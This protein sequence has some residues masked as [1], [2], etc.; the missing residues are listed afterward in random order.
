[1]IGVYSRLAL[2]VLSAV[3]L[4]D[5]YCPPDRIHG[6][7]LCAFRIHCTGTIRGVSLP[8]ECRGSI[9]HPVTVDLTLTEGIERFDNHISDTEFLNVVTTFRASAVWQR[10][11]LSFLTYMTRLKTLVLTENQIQRIEGTPFFNL[12]YLQYLDLSRNSLTDIEDLFQFETQP[13]RLEKLFLSNNS[14]EEIPGDAFSELTSLKE[15]DLSHNLISNFDEEPFFNLTSLE[16]LRLNNNRI[17]DLN[18]AVNK[19]VNL[20]H[21]Y[22]KG[23]QIQNI[24]DPSLKIIYHL[25]TFD[26]SGNQLEKLRPIMFSRHWQHFGGVVRIIL[27]ENHITSV[28]NG[29]SSEVSARFTRELSKHT[30]ETEVS[31]ELDLSKNLISNIE[32]HA[33]QS[34]VRLINLDLSQNKL[35]DFII[36]AGDLRDVK[37]L[38]LSFNHLTYLYFES[39]SLMA[40]LQNLDLSHNRL[41]Y[42]AD[43]TF[44][45]NY[46]LKYVNMTHNGIAVLKRL[47]ISMFHS[48]GGVLDLSNN[49][50]SR[51][52]IPIGEGL[53]LTILVLNSNSI[54]DAE[55]INL[56]YQ[57]DL[58]TLEM[59]KNYIQKL[60]ET[61]LRLPLSLTSLDLSYNEIEV[62]GP[63][64]FHRVAHLT[65]L[66]LG[67]NKL[68]NIQYGVFYGLTSLNNLDLSFNNIKYLDSKILMDLKSLSV[69]SLRSN[70]L[71]LLD[72]KGWLGH[73][74][75]LKVY[76][77]D[78]S[79]SCNWLSEA[80][81]DFNNGYSKMRPTVR[82]FRPAS[83][84]HSLEGIPCVQESENQV[85][86][87]SSYV[88]ADERLLVTNQKILEAVKEQTYFLRSFMNQ[89][90]VNGNRFVTLRKLMKRSNI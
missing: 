51:L 73:K 21:L 9:N 8:D 44:T 4:A 88:L 33:F 41:D 45:K 68:T 86:L 43:E 34:I 85:D 37:Y 50:L 10:T 52:G 83:S 66:Y 74:Y 28:P 3:T 82:Q 13:N 7:G 32:Y 5:S 39:F 2:A 90:N 22:L 55:F 40:N 56:V 36:H 64:T 53:R 78:N 30:V 60:N 62:I 87:S 57:N 29:T 14:I 11:A 1:M 35:T 31:T 89:F 49:G 26:V 84:N 47:G 19:L 46:N 63:S 25:R 48:D 6:I 12:K 42:I 18:G 75:D 54:V 61:S 58:K 79:F 17:K 67:H 70:G 80:L 69:L 59:R 23:N 65:S 24:D 72:Y 71:Y 38:N 76:L 81:R 16:I 15:L 20:K 27:S 77:E